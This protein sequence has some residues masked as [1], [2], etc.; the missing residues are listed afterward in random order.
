MGANPLAQK[1]CQAKRNP[2]HEN[3]ANLTSSH[4]QRVGSA[5]L[6]VRYLTAG[7]GSQTNLKRVFL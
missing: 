3:R 1:R 5:A 6:V 2:L 7:N 4:R